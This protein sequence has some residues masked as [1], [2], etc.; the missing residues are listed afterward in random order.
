MPTRIHNVSFQH[1]KLLVQSSLLIVV[2]DTGS[3]E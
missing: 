3:W 1:A 2:N